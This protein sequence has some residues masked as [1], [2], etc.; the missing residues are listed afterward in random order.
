ME[1]FTCIQGE[2]VL[3]LS[4]YGVPLGYILVV[5]L[6]SSPSAAYFSVVGLNTIET[7]YLKHLLNEKSVTLIIYFPKTLIILI[8]Q[9]N[10]EICLIND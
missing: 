6:E 9:V 1:K 5:V 3:L 8:A 10:T 4:D 7:N 2:I